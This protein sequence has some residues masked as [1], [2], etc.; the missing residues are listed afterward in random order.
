[1]RQRKSIGEYL[2]YLSVKYD[3]EPEKFLSAL[4]QARAGM[5][6]DC[7][8]FSIECR[9]RIEKKQIFLVRNETGVVAQFRVPDEFF[10]EVGDS[11]G[12]FMNTPM[13]RGL[14]FKKRKAGHFCSIR[15][16]KSGMTHINLKAKVLSVA[17]QKHVMTRYGNYADV[18]K[19]LI[20]DETGAINLLLWNDQINAV[21]VGGTVQVSDARASVFRGEKQLTVGSKGVLS[22]A[23]GFELEGAQCLPIAL[24][25]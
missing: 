17:E 21:S 15:D 22:D 13:L 2:A 14:L 4:R 10:L 18:A 3:I 23:E 24:E 19:A 5:K 16:V 11:I 6:I 25:T 9:G 8:K 12:K 20:G 7:G 1:M